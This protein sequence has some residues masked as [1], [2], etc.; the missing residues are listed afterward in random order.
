MKLSKIEWTEETWNPVIGCNEV[1]EGCR[2]CYAKVMAR[3]LQGMGVSAYKDGFKVKM[4]PDRLPQPLKN[5]KPTKYFVNSMSDLFHNEVTFEFIDKV[6][7]II[8]STPY[9]TY[10]ILTKREK[11]LAEYFSTRSCPSNV[12]L[13]VT[14]EDKQRGVPRMD[15]LRNI[16]ATI[17]F[18]SAEPLLEDLGKIDLTGIHWVIVGGESGN[19]ARPMSESW[20][21]NIRKQCEIANVAFFFKQW[22]TW[23]ADGKKRNKALNGKKLEGKIHQDYPEILLQNRKEQLPNIDAISAMSS[24]Y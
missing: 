8:R 16:D 15:Y 10:Q 5:K 14:V 18:I 7:D 19:Q 23:G 9:H 2:H 4:L 11:R 20:A 24:P 17:R 12:W 22:G 3:R 21:I 1:S 13:G 6:F